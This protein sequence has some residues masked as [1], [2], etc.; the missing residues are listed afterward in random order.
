[1][2]KDGGGGSGLGNL[3]AFEK[4]LCMW[5]A[6]DTARQIQLSARITVV[7]S[8]SFLL[9]ILSTWQLDGVMTAICHSRCAS[10]IDIQTFDAP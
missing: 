2:S 7:G 10:S 5:D 9:R 3:R 4:G 1:M 8:E 6:T